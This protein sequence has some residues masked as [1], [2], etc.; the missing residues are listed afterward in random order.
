MAL[1][2]GAQRAGIDVPGALSVVGYDDIDLARFVS[3][4][5][6]TMAVD[7]LGM[8]RLAV[9]MLL[10]RL[11]FAQAAVVQALIRPRLVE[12]GS[13]RT[14]ETLAATTGEAVRS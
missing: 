11:E 7:K 12:R 4:Q 8:G 6:T 1:I 10:H 2:Q 13:V 9:T 14:I 5:L 3:P